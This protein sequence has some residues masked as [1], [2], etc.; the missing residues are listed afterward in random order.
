MR[1]AHNPRL[2]PPRLELED[3]KPRE[4]GEPGPRLCEKWPHRPANE[5]YVVLCRARELRPMD[6]SAL[7]GLGGGSEG[8]GG[9]SDPYVRLHIARG[10]G[11]GARPR[12]P[13]GRAQE[14]DQVQ[15]AQ[16]RVA[17]I[18]VADPDAALELTVN[19]YDLI[20]DDDFGAVATRGRR[21][22]RVPRRVWHTLGDEA[23]GRDGEEERGRV[24]LL[25]WWH[26]NRENVPA[27][28]DIELSDGEELA[29]D[30]RLANR[31]PNELRV[32]VVRA[33]DVPV[34]DRKSI[35]EGGGAD[36]AARS[37]CCGS[38]AP[39]PREYRDPVKKD[40]PARAGTSAS[41]ACAA[42]RAS[43]AT[44]CRRAAARRRTRSTTTT[45]TTCGARR[46]R[47]CRGSSATCTTTPPG[48]DLIGW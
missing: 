28:E 21:L 8:Q 3:E 27:G 11:E 38:A 43:C 39:S 7:S 48:R 32:R 42:C 15:G 4:D 5:L 18:G 1:W 35:F 6:F 29:V 47:R 45:P 46:A 31:P 24:E 9:T 34:M 41:V 36:A 44:S 20:G 22:D 30:P 10:V 17:E 14:R 23:E 40:T 25:L 2:E 19:D 26:H 12:R 16:P 33:R 37:A 13:R